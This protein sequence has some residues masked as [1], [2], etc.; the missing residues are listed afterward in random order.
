MARAEFFEKCS[1]AAQLILES[2]VVAGNT[3]CVVG[4][5][6]LAGLFTTYPR[7][8][9]GEGSRREASPPSSSVRSPFEIRELRVS[10][11]VGVL[12]L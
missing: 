6:L 2:W 10:G 4:P 9:G 8:K 12:I 3:V 1:V 7:D 5:L 11:P